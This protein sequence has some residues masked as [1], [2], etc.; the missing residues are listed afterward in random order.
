MKKHG[1][2]LLLCLAIS[3]CQEN[4]GEILPSEEFVPAFIVDTNLAQLAKRV[5]VSNQVAFDVKDDQTNLTYNKVADVS[6]NQV[7]GHILSATGVAYLDDLVYV[8]YH[9]RGDVYGG[10]I[11]TFDVS[12]PSQPQLIS[13]LVD[14]FAD[15]NDI[16]MG[17]FS[18]NVWVAGARDIYNSGYENTDGAIATKIGLNNDKTPKNV[19]SWE[20]PLLSYSASSITRVQPPAGASNGRIFI[21]SGSKGGLEVVRG[22]DENEIFHS[23][24][25]DNAKHFDY[26][27]EQGVF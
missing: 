15:Y 26:Y 4:N 12:S 11:L 25:S 1:L 21:T 24:Q 7:N 16:M 19:A 20:I 10:E 6:P 13:S 18:S 3:S 2:I 22:N 27:N 8:T 14:E 23:R 9:V 5:S 17:Q